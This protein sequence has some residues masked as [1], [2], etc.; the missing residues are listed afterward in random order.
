VPADP[1]DGLV[2]L[3]DSGRC[4]GAPDFLQT[5]GRAGETARPILLEDMLLLRR[6]PGISHGRDEPLG[7]TMTRL[8]SVTPP[9]SRTQHRPDPAAM[10]LT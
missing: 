8:S 3:Y 1:L 7:S 9:F 6:N 2:S 10:L 4:L 5:V